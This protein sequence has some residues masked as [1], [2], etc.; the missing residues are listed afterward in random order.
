MN[1][2]I[3]LFAFVFILSASTCLYASSNP[4]TLQVMAQSGL[5][6]RA[7][8]SLDAP[9]IT[10]MPF[11]AYVNVVAFED[12]TSMD[13][14]EWIDGK[15][16]KID[17]NGK[18]GYAFDG[19]LTVFEVP[20]STLETVD[21]QLFF[22]NAVEFWARSQFE[23]TS[24][25]TFV[26]SGSFT[27]VI[28]NFREHN[29]LKVKEYELSTRVEL[30]LTDTRVMEVYQLLES[31][32]SDKKALKRFKDASIFIEDNATVNRVKI[33]IDNPIVIKRIGDK[34]KVTIDERIDGC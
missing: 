4:T 34:V 10:L 3:K 1:N 31:M 30:F 26:Q 15:W 6:L 20:K 11:G 13:R 32:I 29:L 28:Y 7:A 9:V 23:A 25:D 8:A 19:F 12:S 21:A 2:V 5:K 22:A 24:I 17:Y 27:Q 16:V 18:I 33:N 14:I